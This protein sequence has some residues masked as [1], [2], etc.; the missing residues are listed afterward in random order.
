MLFLIHSC[1][2]SLDVKYP[3]VYQNLLKISLILSKKTYGYLSH[4]YVMGE[5]AHILANFLEA[6]FSPLK[7]S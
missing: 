5:L 3:F 4:I 1:M 7:L 2:C 6:C